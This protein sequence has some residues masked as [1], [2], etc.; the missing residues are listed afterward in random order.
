MEIDVAPRMNL[1]DLCLD[2]NVRAGRGGKAAVVS[3]QGEYTY[4]QLTR[5]SARVAG[6]LTKLG[7][8][9]EQRA[10]LILPDSWELVVSYFGVMRMGGVAVP[11]ST[12]M[13]TPDYEYLLA[14]SR[15]R[16]LV[17]HAQ[18]LDQVPVT[19][20]WLRHVIVVGHGDRLANAGTITFDQL[21]ASGD[22]SFPA[23][24]VSC[25]DP[26]FWLY[27]S[28][29]T[30]FPNGV[31]HLHQDALYS[32]CY[33]RGVLQADDGVRTLSSSKLFFAYGIGCSLHVPLLAGGTTILY[34]GRATPA[35]IAAL[36]RQHRPT[37]FFSVPTF[38]ASSLRAGIALDA[39]D[40]VRFCVSAGEALPPALYDAWLRATGKELVEHIG[41]TEF[42]YAF[43]S[44]RPGGVRPGSSGTPVPGVEARIVDED[45]RDVEPGQ[46][47]VLLIRGGSTAI[48]YW[49][50][51]RQTKE[52]FL[53]EWLRTGDVYYQDPDGYFWNCG[54]GDD[55]LKVSGIWVS[56]S[57]VEQALAEHEQVVEA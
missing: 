18:Y 6:G 8:D 36:A 50:K 26:A 48:G 3:P 28:G 45:G 41:S 20:P 19:S 11:V 52:T 2:G 46:M 38:F 42:I 40:S 27:S 29:T 23:L 7:L 5:L 35:D 53:G 56:P 15:A 55:L 4:E 10:L 25:D 32:A 43:I 34:P 1:A 37:I 33:G 44:N 22:D 54:R 13:R 47:G 14:D 39:Y 9:P 16:V 12:L 51:R 49:N 57:E 31:I 24:T 30:G 17:V 21:L